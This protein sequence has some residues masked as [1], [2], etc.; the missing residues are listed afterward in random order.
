[1]KSIATAAIGLLPNYHTIGIWAPILLTLARCLQGF[2]A[3]GEYAGAVTYV[4]E[5]APDD[6]RSRY[7]SWM[8]AAT[9]A[10]FALAALISYLLTIGLSTEAMNGWGWRVPFLLAAPLGLVAL[11]I[12]SRLDESPL[13]QAVLDGPAP[14]H[15]QLGK[16]MREQWIPMVRLGAYISLTALSFYIFSTYMTTFLR[17]VVRDGAGPRAALE[18]AGADPRGGDGAVPRAE[19][20]TASAGGRR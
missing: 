16:T 20:A 9:F 14:A 18:R 13:F 5:H 19:S 8:P 2:S 6:Q 17:S 3:G 12:R 15:A 11:Y 10:S 4:I 7:S 1:M